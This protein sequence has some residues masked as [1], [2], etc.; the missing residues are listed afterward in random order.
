[1]TTGV[2]VRSKRTLLAIS[3]R[4]GADAS[5]RTASRMVKTFRKP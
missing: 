3:D 4:A 1:V 5:G 2:V